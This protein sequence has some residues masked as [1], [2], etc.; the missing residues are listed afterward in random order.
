[1]AERQAASWVPAS[2]LRQFLSTE[3]AGGYVL[4]AAAG[5]ALVV[6]NSPLAHVYEAALHFPVAGHGLLHW[7]ND[8]LMAIFFLLIGLEVKRELIDGELATNARRV[9]PGAAALAGMAVPAAIYLAFNHTNPAARDGWAIPAATDIAFALGI[10]A[11]LGSRVPP[12]L[13]ILLTAIAIIDDLGAIV[14]IA[15]AYTLRLDYIDLGLAT[16]GIAALVVLN[17]MRV[18]VLWPYLLIGVGVWYEVLLSGVHAT[19]AG[20]AIAF[21]IPLRGA[22]GK[23]DDTHSPLHRLEHALAPIVAFVIVPVFGFAN[24][25]VALLHLTPADAV[26]PVPLGVAAGLFL[27]KQIGVFGAIWAMVK[28]GLADKPMGATW[29]QIYGV[30]VLCGIGFTMSLFIAAL[31]FG[32]GTAENEIAKLGII[33]GSFVAALAGWAI[34]AGSRPEA[35]PEPSR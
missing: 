25:G 24:A 18:T 21:C 33:G 5:A 16:A 20:V 11:L 4:M 19:L 29:R 23:I 35:R 8:G 28:L 10:L 31:A 13:K 27:G 34:L 7:I 14:I 30:A 1:M 2:A 12:S 9:L 22:P 17:R 3:A 6:A 32:Q 26:A 15:V